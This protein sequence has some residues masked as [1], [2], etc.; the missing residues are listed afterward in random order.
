MYSDWNFTC[1]FE[2]ILLSERSYLSD[3]IE[4]RDLIV[5]NFL[6]EFRGIAEVIYCSDIT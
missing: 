6:L 5:P 1:L 2:F 3:F 4:S